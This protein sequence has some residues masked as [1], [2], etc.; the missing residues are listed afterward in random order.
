[1]QVLKSGYRSRENPS[2]RKS[3]LRSRAGLWMRR[4]QDWAW[5]CS[6]LLGLKCVGSRSAE[7]VVIDEKLDHAAVGT[8]GVVEQVDLVIAEDALN[9]RRLRVRQHAVI[10]AQ[11]VVDGPREVQDFR[12]AHAVDIDLEAP[13]GE[14]R[15]ARMGV[16][17]GFRDHLVTPGRERRTLGQR[18]VEPAERT[19]GEDGCVALYQL[20]DAVFD[21]FFPSS[22]TPARS[23][24]VKTLS[25]ARRPS[26]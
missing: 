26:S 9:A 7:V 17:G 14:V 4:R 13:F 8:A 24:S 23:S 18:E 3:R 12:A 19:L 11:H 21:H 5:R 2:L 20:H 1:M 6:S 10:A 15:A 16:F 22:G 25:A